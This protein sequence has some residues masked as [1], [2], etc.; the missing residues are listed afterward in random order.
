MSYSKYPGAIDDNESMPETVD[1]VTELKAEVVNRLRD[2]IIATET[3]IG[4]NPTDGY[5]TIKDRLD[6]MQTEIDA[7]GGV[8][9]HAPTHEEGGSDEI[10]IQ[11][12]G[13][14]GAAADKVLVTDGAGGLTLQDYIPHRILQTQ[15]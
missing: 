5:A 12:L 8:S 1:L 13:S 11:N 9:A 3:T 10:A 6:A 2:G 15:M 14:A 4:A 7:G